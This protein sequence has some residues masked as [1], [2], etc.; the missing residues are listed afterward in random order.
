MP[1][2]S[3]IVPV[4]KVEKY[5]AQC[6]KS[7]QEQTFNDIEIILVDDGSPDS[8]GDICDFYTTKDPRIRVVH[9]ENQ[10]LSCARNVGIK[11]S[12]GEFVCFVDSDDY[13]APD[14]CE[15]LYQMLLETDCDYSV[16]GVC[17]FDENKEPKPQQND[18]QG[19]YSNLVF[20][21]MQ[22]S[23]KSEF[24]VWNKLYR[25]GVVEKI[26]FFP[27]KIHED[28]IW[29]ADLA[30]NFTNGVVCSNRQLYYYRQNNNG[31]VKQ[32]AKKCSPD[33][34][35]AGEYLADV[36][37]KK[38]S[39]YYDMALKYVIEY[40][41]MFIDSIYVHKE[42]KENREFL[43]EMQ[44]YLRENIQEYKEKKIFSDICLSR[45]SVFAKSKILY[46]AN[47]Y[48]RLLRVFLYRILH[49]DAYKDGHGV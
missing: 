1:T 7:I 44:R 26:S 27:K 24:G 48:A 21:E 25:R 45:M 43:N 6:I 8:C 14:Y 4:Y 13:I 22:L 29:S 30:D 38:G 15:V 42:W 32:G 23:K 18:L 36:L 49:L 20:L 19:R 2:I 41:W 33:R 31:I 34:I 5:L 37:K 40:P 17:R 35:F 28:V 46:A 9:Q 10:G 47:V 3:V 12:T 16:C 11:V 39:E